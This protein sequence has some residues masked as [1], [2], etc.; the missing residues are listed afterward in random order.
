MKIKTILTTIIL[1]TILSTVT[2]HA[3]GN[4]TLTMNVTSQDSNSI[5]I[6]LIVTSPTQNINSVQY[7]VQYDP[8]ILQVTGVTDNNPW[9]V[10]DSSKNTTTSNLSSY[11]GNYVSLSLFINPPVMGNSTLAKISFKKVSSGGTSINWIS[12]NS[13]DGI[14]ASDGNATNIINSGGLSGYTVSGTTPTTSTTTNPT[15]VVTTTAPSSRTLPNT[16]ILDT[17]IIPTIF[18]IILILSALI[19]QRKHH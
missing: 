17:L 10:A 1:A 12:K 13:S 7:S 4:G 5:N 6:D 3:Q 16:G 11:T 19:L 15:P 8:T 9:T 14:F 2:I 18:C